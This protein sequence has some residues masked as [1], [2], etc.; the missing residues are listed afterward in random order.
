MKHSV[1]NGFTRLV[2]V[3]IPLETWEELMEA[4]ECEGMNTTDI[5]CKC[6]NAALKDRAIVLARKHSLERM[7]RKK[8]VNG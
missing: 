3:R 4:K 1:E 2:S 7:K 6:I 5:I 8:E